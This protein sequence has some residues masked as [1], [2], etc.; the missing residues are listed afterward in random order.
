LKHMR[1]WLAWTNGPEL[2]NVQTNAGGIA[3]FHLPDPLPNG[4]AWLSSPFVEIRSSSKDSS[5]QV[6]LQ[7]MDGENSDGTVKFPGNPNP[8]KLVLFVRRLNVFQ[9]MYNF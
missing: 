9:T 5:D 2:P 8:G 6:F 7:G 4:R 3:V 1:L